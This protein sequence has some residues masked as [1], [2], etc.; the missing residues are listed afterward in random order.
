MRHVIFFLLAWA[1]TD[2]PGTA[3]WLTLLAWLIF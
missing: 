3:F 1:A 2:D